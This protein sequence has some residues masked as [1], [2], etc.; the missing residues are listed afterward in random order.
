[1]FDLGAIRAQARMPD[2]QGQQHTYFAGAWMG[3]G[4]HEDG[5]KAGLQAARCLM[6]DLGLAADATVS[7]SAQRQAALPGVFA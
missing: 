5:L 3:Y 2:L 6:R 1:V 7:A 4:F